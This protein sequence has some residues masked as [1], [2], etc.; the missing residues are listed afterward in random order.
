VNTKEHPDKHFHFKA[1]TSEYYTTVT[2]RFA[3]RADS[4]LPDTFDWGLKGLLSY[5]INQHIPTYCGSCW[6]YASVSSLANSNS[7]F[8]SRRSFFGS[9]SSELWHC[10]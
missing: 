7:R 1:E 8:R 2:G 3:G 4:S 9:S 6:V 10:R 5:D